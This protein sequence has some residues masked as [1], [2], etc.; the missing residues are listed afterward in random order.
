MQWR[1]WGSNPRPLG[2]ESSTLLLS[3][4]APYDV[5]TFVCNNLVVLRNC[6]SHICMK[7][8]WHTASEMFIFRLLILKISLFHITFW[9]H[10][11]QNWI[12]D[13]SGWNLLVSWYFSYSRSKK[14]SFLKKCV[15][16]WGLA[17]DL[18]G[19]STWALLSA[20]ELDNIFFFTF[21]FILLFNKLKIFTFSWFCI[22]NK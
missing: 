2:L 9:W 8:V 19:F 22:D 21:T 11:Y 15:I 6:S 18:L 13:I 10:C 20:I 5:H 7:H 12:Q 1:R 4:C 14:N 17:C 16:F 3:H